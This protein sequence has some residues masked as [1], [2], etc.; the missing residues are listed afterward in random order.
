MSHLDIMVDLET[1]GTDPDAVVIQLSG[2]VYDRKTGKTM[3]EFDEF[4]SPK[5]ALDAKL[6]ISASAMKWWFQQ[7][8]R[9]FKKIILGAVSKGKDI[10]EVL[11]HF[12]NFLEDV[13]TKYKTN[14]IHLWGNGTMSDNV[15]ID[16]CYRN[17]NV[18]NPFKYFEHKD[19]RT[20]VQL[21]EDILGRDCRDDIKFEGLEHDALADCYH[22]IKFCV[23]IYKEI[24]KN[25]K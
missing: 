1:L 16:N 21:G 12:N 6:T 15:W 3:E 13:K 8:Q 18:K 25:K 2:V 14:S 19:V 10:T 23:K 22:Q 11:N 7:D 4:I 17:T 20:L 9:V 24:I 5:S